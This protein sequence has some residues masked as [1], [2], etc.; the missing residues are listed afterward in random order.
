MI[1]PAREP[2]SLVH[3]QRVLLGVS[4]A[5]VTL[6]IF[7]QVFTRYV[8][9]ISIYGIEDLAS[10]IA[11][12]LY[13]I[14]GSLGAWERGHISASLVDFIVKSDRPRRWINAASAAITTILSGWMTVWAARIFLVHRPKRGQMS[15]EI[16]LPMSYVTVVMPVGLAL[17]TFYFLIETIDLIG[18]ARSAAR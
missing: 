16:E 8:L 17:M 9:H 12:W 15:L 18:R 4:G 5:L 7:V 14:G 2:D 1:V 13:F 6:L 3:A 10:F 11:V